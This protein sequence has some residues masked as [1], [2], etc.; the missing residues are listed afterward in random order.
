[1][2]VL[3]Y[4]EVKPRMFMKNYNYDEPHSWLENTRKKR[5]EKVFSLT[6]AENSVCIKVLKSLI[7]F[8]HQ[9]DKVKMSH[10]AAAVFFLFSSNQ[11][12]RFFFY[13]FRKH[14]TVFCIELEYEEIFTIRRA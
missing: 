1:M 14:F 9:R 5:V 4:I 3:C 11:Q 8:F 13:S 10:S 6:T 12:K 7:T 2:E